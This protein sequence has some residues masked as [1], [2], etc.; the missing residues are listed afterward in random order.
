MKTI[1]VKF[2]KIEICNYSPRETIMDI[3]ITIDNNGQ[4]KQFLKKDKI[5]N[6]GDLALYILSKMKKSI[7]EKSF[8]DEEGPL[9]GIVVVRLNDEE[10]I[11]KMTKF[12]SSVKDRI[13]NI[14]RDKTI[15]YFRMAEKINGMAMNF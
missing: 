5:G 12:L 2:K 4:E 9:G 3:K 15:T 7:K 14:Q 10:I 11:D 6:P 8:D 1:D 13:N